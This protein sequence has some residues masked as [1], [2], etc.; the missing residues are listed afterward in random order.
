MLL[1]SYF[2]YPMQYPD[3][4]F[5]YFTLL[6]YLVVFSPQKK[7]DAHILGTKVLTCQYFDITKYTRDKTKHFIE[8]VRVG[9]NLKQLWNIRTD[10]G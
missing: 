6:M 8:V 9:G 7:N 10:L 1:Q 2:N 4:G 3:I 5:D